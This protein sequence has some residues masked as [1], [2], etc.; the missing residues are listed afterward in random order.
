MIEAQEPMP[1][2]LVV[3]IRKNKVLELEGVTNAVT[4]GQG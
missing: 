4:A 3:L 1:L 2:K